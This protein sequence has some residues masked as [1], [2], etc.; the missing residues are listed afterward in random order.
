MCG[1]KNVIEKKF[2]DLEQKNKIEMNQMSEALKTLNKS[3]ASMERES[4]IEINKEINEVKMGIQMLKNRKDEDILAK[5]IEKV[6]AALKLIQTDAKKEVAIV[7]ND[8]SKKVI[9]KD[10]IEE[11]IIKGYQNDC[12]KI[13]VVHKKFDL[14]NV[15]CK[16]CGFESHSEGLL[17]IHKH[18]NHKSNDTFET[19]VEGFEND[20][21]DHVRTLEAMC[22]D[23]NVINRMKC[24]KC[25]YKNNSEGNLKIHERET[26][27]KS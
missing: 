8:E 16:Q 17:R 24:D 23:D 19:I 10:I 6:E 2:K 3:F 7:K 9:T 18:E 26:H 11:N 25:K 21:H 15:V 5:K 14:D 1:D 27:E 4:K 12:E 20:I 22:E 13:L